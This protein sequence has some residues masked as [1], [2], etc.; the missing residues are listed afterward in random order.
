MS[1]GARSRSRRRPPGRV[2]PNQSG[3]LAGKR[4]ELAVDAV[5]AGG[6]CVARYDGR[7]V[8]VRHTLPGERVLAL[9]T[10]DRGGSYCR[11]D[12]VE[13]LDA[14]PDRVEP[15][16]PHAGPG[17]CGGCD[18]QHVRPERQRELKADLVRSALA[19]I[20]GVDPSAGPVAGLVVHALDPPDLGWRTRAQFAV[21][22]QGRLGLR[23]HRSHEIEPAAD[24]PLVTAGVR[25]ALVGRH[26]PPGSIVE[27]TDAG[28][29]VVVDMR[30]KRRATGP[31]PELR[32][33]AL[34]HQFR[35]H[36]GSF[37][38]V[39]PQAAAV[40]AHCVRVLLAPRPGERVLDLFAGVGLFGTALADATGA[41]RQVTVVEADPTA[42]ADAAVN[43]PGATVRPEPVT[44]DLVRRERADLVVLDPPRSG[45]GI[46][47]TTAILGVGARA[48]AY[49]ACDPAALARDIKAATA[50]GWML[51][52]LRAFDLFPMT[53]HVECVAILAPGQ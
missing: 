41:P 49:V 6:Q 45:A 17:R 15:P 19:R 25:G 36:G 29:T 50:A 34:G 8:F 23:R 33:H 28:G 24:C 40:L 26:D 52:D 3:P 12:A 35:L 13:I 22:R 43:L 10:W 4:I 11:A 21:D 7:V 9:V 44:V 16:C 37:W 53:E 39:H 32:E 46:D 48:V 30:R 31:R 2:R 47:L 1:A 51:R 18:W 38:Q 5:A 14:A 27:V 20:G 42:A